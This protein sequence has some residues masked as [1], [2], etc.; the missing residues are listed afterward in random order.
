[1]VLYG[2]TKGGSPGGAAFE[3]LGE[4]GRALADARNLLKLAPRLPKCAETVARLEAALDDARHG[5]LSG[6]RHQR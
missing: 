3:A 5:S 1:M 2:R 6:T 4:L